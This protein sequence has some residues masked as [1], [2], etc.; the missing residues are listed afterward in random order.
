[1][2]S[3]HGRSVEINEKKSN[4]PVFHRS[5]AVRV[6]NIKKS[7]LDRETAGVRLEP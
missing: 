4:A 3:T 7:S 1:L 5:V 6:T 2:N